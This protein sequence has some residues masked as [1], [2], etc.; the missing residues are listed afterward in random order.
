MN[1]KL[2][3]GN[4]WRIGWNPTA[5]QF[6]GLVGGDT[7]AIELTHSEFKDFCRLAQQLCSTMADMATQLMDE[8]R[9]SCEQETEA[10]WLEVEGF[11]THYDLRFILL[12]GRKGEGAWPAIVVDELIKAIEQV[13]PVADD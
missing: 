1:R 9:L 2:L 10:I 11:P 6:S 12:L 13:A 8:E 3:S 7:W 4:G 5:E